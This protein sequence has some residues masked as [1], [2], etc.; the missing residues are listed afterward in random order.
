MTFPRRARSPDCGSLQPQTSK[1]LPC[2]QAWLCL[3]I[4]GLQVNLGEGQNLATIFPHGMGGTG[5]LCERGRSP[6]IVAMLT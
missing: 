4:V 6:R 2:F 5:Q 1:A 3:H